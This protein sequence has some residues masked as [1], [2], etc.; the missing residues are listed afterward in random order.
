MIGLWKIGWSVT[1]ETYR[2][3]YAALIIYI[4]ARVVADATEKD[5]LNDRAILGLFYVPRRLR[6]SA[7]LNHVAPGRR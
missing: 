3:N 2:T 1:L 4:G 7:I 5:D 6:H